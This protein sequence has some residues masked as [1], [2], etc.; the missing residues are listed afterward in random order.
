MEANMEANKEAYMEANKEAYMEAYMEANMEIVLYG[1]ETNLG[2]EHALF[3]NKLR[4]YILKIT[5]FG[6]QD[7]S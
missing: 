1:L 3:K 7:Y 5:P 2:Q 4:G 6:Q